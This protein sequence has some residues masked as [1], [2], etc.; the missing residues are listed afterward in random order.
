M[1]QFLT[2]FA[3]NSVIQRTSLIPK[4]ESFFHFTGRHPTPAASN[5]RPDANH[6]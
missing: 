3:T 5:I 1:V 6:K 4:I 2:E